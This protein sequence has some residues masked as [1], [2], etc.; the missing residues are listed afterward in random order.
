MIRKVGIF[1]GIIILFGIIIYKTITIQF[2]DKEFERAVR[3]CIGRNDIS[4]RN[5][6]EVAYTGVILRGDLN[7]I[8]EIYIDIN[9]YKI[10]DLR[11]LKYFENLSELHLSYIPEKDKENTI[12]IPAH[13]DAV[14]ELPHLERLTFFRLNIDEG[15]S[16]I[17]KGVKTLIIDE[18]RIVD[19]DFMKNFSNVELLIL[20]EINIGSLE[21]IEDMQFL[22]T[23]QLSYNKYS[24]SLDPLALAG[25]LTELNIFS[26]IPEIFEQLPL[27]PSLK[28]LYLGGET[29]PTHEDA[30]SY[31]G[32]DNLTELCL[33]GDKYDVMTGTW[34]TKED[35]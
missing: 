23:L 30:K 22:S 6:R 17:H 16:Q 10:K 33:N 1:V 24:C 28:K 13:I 9:K 5:D 4:M 15:F 35:K 2:Y 3:E 7:R 20:R 29:I 34:S 12:D 25:N 21:F 8:E 27:I 19:F 31:V 18:C 14:L 32:W 26:D 11:D